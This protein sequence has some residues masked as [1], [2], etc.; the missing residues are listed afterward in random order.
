[1]PDTQPQAAAETAAQATHPFLDLNGEQF[2]QHVR[3]Q[4]ALENPKFEVDTTFFPPPGTNAASPS[5]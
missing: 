4:L 1:M 2:N 3:A 5:P